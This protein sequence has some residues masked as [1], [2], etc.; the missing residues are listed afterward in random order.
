MK[1]NLPPLNALRVFEV[2]A[3]SE[4]FSKTADILCVTQSAVSKQMRLLEEHLDASLFHRQ[5]TNLQLTAEGRQ[6]LSKISKAMDIIELGSEHF[7][8]SHDKEI[9]TINIMPSLSALWMFSRVEV[10]Q[11]LHPN[12]TI[13]IDSENDV[14]DSTKKKMDIALRCFPSDKKYHGAELLFNEKLNLVV[15]PKLNKKTPIDSIEDLK[16]HQLIGLNT[17]PFLWEE[18]FGLYNQD[19]SGTN[20]CFSCEHFYMVIQAAVEGLGIGMVPDFLCK[21]FIR[22]GALLKV[23]DIE[24]MSSYAYYL[25]TPPHK[26]NDKNVL[27]FERWIK[28]ALVD[29]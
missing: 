21:D 12:I 8:V 16:N 27:Q 19:D 15:S 28:N 6:Y 9:L 14:I 10:F 7:Y 17:R 4:S 1:R 22:K 5:G 3:K 24:V 11:R 18:F 25:I 29:S 26:K 20:V 23:L 2:A 13:N